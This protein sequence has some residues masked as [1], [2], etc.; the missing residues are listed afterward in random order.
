MTDFT[1]LSPKP[2]LP[3]IERHHWINTVVGIIDSVWH[4]TPEEQFH[5]IRVVKALLEHLS[6]PERGEPR[7][8]PA[9]LA[10]EV[11]GGFYNLQLNSTQDSGI[12]RP[13]RAPGPRDYNLPMEVWC[14]S[15]VNLFTTAYPDLEP[16]E[17]LYLTKGFLDLLA[18]LGAPHRAPAYVPEDVSR[19]ARDF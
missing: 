12:A 1:P 9:P 7:E 14:Q 19:A 8:V 6:I 16:L 18:S 3:P 10:L 4:L 17:R 13:V 15:L 2:V 11:D 5:T